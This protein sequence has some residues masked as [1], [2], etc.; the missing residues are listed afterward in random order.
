MPKRRVTI[1]D[2][3]KELGVTPSTVSRALAGNNR[4]RI[5]TRE[6]VLQT[7]RS[8]GYQPNVL[9]SSLRRGS[10]LTIGM[11]VPRINRNFFSHVISG[12]EEVLNPA[13]YNLL[14]SQTHESYDLEQKAVRSFLSNRVAGIIISHSVETK[15]FDHLRSV[16]DEGISL[17][18]FDRV[19]SG[20][21]GSRIVND[22][23]LGGLRSTQHLIRSGCRRI[24][25]FAGALHVNVYK[26]RFEGYRYAL[27]QAGIEYDPD[28]IIEN[29][30][31]QGKGAEAIRKLV[32]ETNIDAVFAASDYSALGALEELKK[33][34]VSVP[35]TLC[36][37]GFANEP[38][39]KW[40]FPSL[41]SVEQNAFEMGN[42]VARAVIDNLEK[43]KFTDEEICVPVRLIPR[44]SS[45]VSQSLRVLPGE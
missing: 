12:V 28:L 43:K 35:E 15:N 18:Q 11:I 10:S 26:D 44:E 40:I 42:Q 31:I 32:L 17:V 3:A 41:S 8:M 19:S 14:I 13:G 39:S 29:C 16:M 9:A 21:G 30:I 25:H 34:K 45:M 27:A 2:I 7:A 36:V 1:T 4:V 33:M 20:L 37:T 22:N 6:K 24:A 38:F 5:K 23:F